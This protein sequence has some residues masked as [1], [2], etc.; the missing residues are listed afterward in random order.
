MKREWELRYNIYDFLYYNLH[1]KIF[2]FGVYYIRL[3]CALG[4]VENKIIVIKR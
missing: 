1:F 2:E 4:F 3:L